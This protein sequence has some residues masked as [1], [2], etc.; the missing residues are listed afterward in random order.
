MDKAIIIHNILQEWRKYHPRAIDHV[1]EYDKVMHMFWDERS[2][3]LLHLTT[4]IP[5]EF[6]SNPDLKYK[7]LWG[8]SG[9]EDAWKELYS[10]C[11]SDFY[12]ERNFPNEDAHWAGYLEERV[13]FSLGYSHNYYCL[14]VPVSK[15][16]PHAQGFFDMVKDC[17]LIMYPTTFQEWEEDEIVIFYSGHSMGVISAIGSLLRLPFTADLE[18]DQENEGNFSRHN[19]LYQT[20]DITKEDFKA[21]AIPKETWRTLLSIIDNSFGYDTKELPLTIIASLAYTFAKLEEQNAD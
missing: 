3:Q 17:P 19:P 14:H 7:D 4:G 18:M 15:D 20:C 6:L 13:S 9:D 11:F 1:H 12:G 2:K 10:A 8:N 21:P 16:Y 5:M